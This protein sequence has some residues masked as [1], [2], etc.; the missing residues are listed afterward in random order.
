MALTIDGPTPA[1]P[2]LSALPS[3]SGLLPSDQRQQ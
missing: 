1:D 3:L 2:F